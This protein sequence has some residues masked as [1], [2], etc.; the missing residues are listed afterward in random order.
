MHMAPCHRALFSRG[1]YLARC[2]FFM[3]KWDGGL[4]RPFLPHEGA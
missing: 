3:T 4:A 1:F 2:D